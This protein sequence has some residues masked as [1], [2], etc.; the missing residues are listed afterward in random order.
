MIVK[1]EP[2]S[3]GFFHAISHKSDDSRRYPNPEQEF[4]DPFGRVLTI[5]ASALLCKTILRKEAWKRPP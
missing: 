2:S 3:T 1:P 5:I 4:P